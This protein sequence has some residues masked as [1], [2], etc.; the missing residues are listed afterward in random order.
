MENTKSENP[1][2]N[3]LKISNNVF[4]IIQSSIRNIDSMVVFL[5]SSVSAKPETF[6]LV[7]ES[8]KNITKTIK[9][10]SKSLSDT[11]KALAELEVENFN[12]V[13]DAGS[14]FMISS[15]KMAI[16]K[17]KGDQFKG[18]ALILAS[19]AKLLG[20]IAE[21]SEYAQKVDS[22][23][24]KNASKATSL[25]FDYLYNTQRKIARKADKLIKLKVP[26][27]I[28]L[29]FSSTNHVISRISETLVMVGG[30]IQTFENIG[31]KKARKQVGES[32]KTI[33]NIYI[34]TIVG[35]IQLGQL[36]FTGTLT[37][38]WIVP[39][40]FRTKTYG[41]GNILKALVALI[42][43]AKYFNIV[44]K[45]MSPVFEQLAVIGTNKKEIKKGLKSLSEI[46]FGYPRIDGLMQWLIN[47]GNLLNTIGA[48]QLIRDIISTS[49]ILTA[50]LGMS[51]L[52]TPTID[53]LITIGR[54]KINI[55]LGLKVLELMLVN[56]ED[57]SNKFGVKPLT[58]I[59]ANINLSNKQILNAFKIIG[60]LVLIT[61]LML[62]IYSSLNFAGKNYKNIKRGI[63][64]TELILLGSN[65]FLGI[66]KKKSLIQIL[67]AITDDDFNSVVRSI[68][69]ISLLTI[70]SLLLN[71]LTLNLAIIGRR[72]K[73][74]KKGV[75]AIKYLNTLLIYIDDINITINEH[76]ITPQKIWN[77]SKILLLI[78]GFLTIISICLTIIGMNIL[79]ITLAIP[80]LLM[81]RVVFVELIW[82]S[83]YLN[84]KEKIII[85]TSAIIRS[86]G[87][88]LFKIATIFMLFIAASLTLNNILLATLCM[89]AVISGMTLA[90]L[91]ILAISLLPLQKISLSVLT[92]IGIA[93]AIFIL[94]FALIQISIN[95]Q[96]INFVSVLMFIGVIAIIASVFAL[97]GLMSPLL[98]LAI[99]GAGAMILIGVSLLL[100]IVPLLL[101]SLLNPEMF[102]K[103]KTNAIL[104]I[105]TCLDII[106]EFMRA[107]Y[108]IMGGGKTEKNDSWIKKAA[109][110]F[111]GG[112]SSV[113]ES[114]F[115][116]IFVSFT[117]LTINIL[118]LMA[119]QLKLLAKINL[120]E[121]DIARSNADA[122]IQTSLDIIGA[123]CRG[124]NM[125]TQRTPDGE[126][127]EK[128]GILQIIL[129]GLK[130][131]LGGAAN[132]IES[133]LSFG[134]VT[135]IMVSIGMITLIAKNLEYL[136]SVKI[137]RGTTVSKVSEILSVAN[138]V[139]NSIT[140]EKVKQKSVR[141]SRRIFKTIKLIEKIAK[142]LNSISEI[143]INKELIDSKISSIIGTMNTCISSIKENSKNNKVS[144]KMIKYVRKTKQI[145]KLLETITKVLS[146]IAEIEFNVK[147][148]EPKIATIISTT[149]NCILVIKNDENK[150]SENEYKDLQTQITQQVDLI[151]KIKRSLI[152]ITNITADI[153]GIT[154][155]TNDVNALVK[156]A[157]TILAPLNA[158]KPG[159]IE[160]VDVKFINGKVFNDFTIVRFKLF[161]N[162]LNRINDVTN[163][164]LG[165]TPATDNENALVEIVNTILAPLNA[166][167][168]GVIEMID[169]K[170]INGKVFNDFTIVR[171][172]L[173]KNNLN[174][175]NDVT[176]SILGITPAT[177][178]ENALVEIVNTILA[179][180]NALQ[181]ATI[182]ISFTGKIGK[183]NRFES[184]KDSLFQ[185]NNI[186]NSIL[187]ITPATD[188]ENALVEIVNTI[189]APL[190]ALQKDSLFNAI[191]N[192]LLNLLSS[193]NSNLNSIAS[194]YDNIVN[195]LISID[196]SSKK[197]KSIEASE[198]DVNNITEQILSNIDVVAKHEFDLKKYNLNID[199]FDKLV[200]SM[201]EVFNL[202]Q[203]SKGTNYKEGIDKAIEFTNTISNAKLEN[204]QTA[205]KLFGKMSEFS[206]TI[207]GNFDG[208]AQTINDKIMPLLEKLNEALDKTNNAIKDGAFKTT[209]VESSDTSSTVPVQT[210]SSIKNDAT[211]Q[212]SLIR[213]A[214]DAQNKKDKLSQIYN[215]VDQVEYHLQKILDKLDWN[216]NVVTT[217]DVTNK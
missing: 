88:L 207:N 48:K 36:L 26:E 57:S 70:M 111:V 173:F 201:Q 7:T 58:Y 178:N 44:F 78:T 24:I 172:K 205:T 66:G 142:K 110:S 151:K 52:L 35:A 139:I 27:A 116:F 102:D 31:G 51:L 215:A 2:K 113:V 120:S 130:G 127:K 214:Q 175:I 183:L 108:R 125:D 146:D 90:I 10:I 114:I 161:K 217:T 165:I 96:K 29:F 79:G 145:F 208:L 163:S 147:N 47:L 39:K 188:N 191:E 73:Q 135:T 140:T 171:F 166:F 5:T 180:L 93:A 157:K 133:I 210:G 75:H 186:T 192:D 112:V 109:L 176:N 123:I 77:V 46:F 194:D 181:S 105:D 132:I 9:V 12:A 50:F 187:G 91:A 124:V 16:N 99:A 95:S 65:G 34:D 87:I 23:S 94:S 18:P 81:L 206:Q 8:T 98:V 213:P 49:L 197:L 149:D 89:L 103:A 84:D 33:F 170:F 61:S 189:L 43:F 138:F 184:L 134:F 150:L 164:I 86:I 4:E 37:R 101:L 107:Q 119:L 28:D 76:Q 126:R 22:K 53:T 59:F 141:Y 83:N 137:N 45:L 174:R 3:H 64:S 155:A 209:V 71:I 63:K 177:D 6:K 62:I 56:K 25:V 204:L 14:I 193:Q 1:I 131:F 202:G 154:P 104:L 212:K 159:V 152:Q 211:N 68:K 15:I 118:L 153:L 97:I 185:I 60:T 148:I 115:S 179:P 117:F 129:S 144:N 17:N 30:L 21:L 128:R 136:S 100:M 85:K 167:K 196:G 143:E 74:I 55:L 67:G 198:V 156:I 42:T 121:L 195:S 69:T 162:N 200:N 72:K 80:A 54:N 20:L 92:I 40:K 122:V 216:K 106:G 190:N 182:E 199:A 41:V 168:P 158:F 203:S 19:Y 38:S 13:I 82:I 160:M 11:V 169:V 32:I